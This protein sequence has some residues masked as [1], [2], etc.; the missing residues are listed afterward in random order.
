MGFGGAAVRQDDVDNIAERTDRLPDD[1][2]DASDLTAEHVVLA[3]EHATLV[4]DVLEHDEHFHNR[5]RWL[6]LQ[7][8][9]TATD[10]ALN[11]LNAF[12][13]VSGNNDYGGDPADEAL[14]LGTD[15]T[16]VVAGNTRFDM[17]RIF[18]TASSVN[19][20][21]KMR[22]IWGT[23]TMADAIT[24]GQFSEVMFAQDN[25]NPQQSV[26]TPFSIIMPRLEAGQDQVWAQAWNVGN[27]ATV[28]FLV[29]LHEYP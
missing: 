17:H 25:A 29:G 14:V 8:P 15:D 18:I 19:T 11:T 1:P 13:A 21:W 3:N 2:A 9:Q 23:G 16:P 5:E 24:A 22:F 10:W 27:N 4:A 20:W 26:G 7:D 28:A 6:G 12:V